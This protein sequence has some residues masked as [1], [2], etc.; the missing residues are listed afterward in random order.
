MRVMQRE[1]NIYIYIGLEEVVGRRNNKGVARDAGLLEGSRGM[2]LSLSL[3]VAAVP[4]T[5]YM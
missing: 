5:L 1:K 3:L 4:L 2:G